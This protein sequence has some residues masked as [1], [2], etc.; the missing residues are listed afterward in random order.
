VKKLLEAGSLLE[1]KD[2]G[3][4]T[5]LFHAIYGNQPDV[6]ELLI[7]GKYVLYLI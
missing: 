3:E 4:C 7:K 6:T 5:P 2:S 1:Y